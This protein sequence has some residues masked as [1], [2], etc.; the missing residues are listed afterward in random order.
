MKVKANHRLLTTVIV[1]AMMSFCLVNILASRNDKDFE[2][3]LEALA[4]GEKWHTRFCEM[5][6]PYGG[7]EVF[8]YQCSSQTSQYYIDWCQLAY[9]PRT[10]PLFECVYKITSGDE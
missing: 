2:S 1:V 8:Y 7:E 9:G 10:T 5:Y 3:N 6:N 4:S